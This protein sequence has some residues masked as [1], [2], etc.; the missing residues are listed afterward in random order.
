MKIEE[1]TQEIF[2]LPEDEYQTLM[3]DLITEYMVRFAQKTTD[4]FKGFWDKA[5]EGIG[6]IEE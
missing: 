1:I 5:L 6:E 2:C 3:I 4:F